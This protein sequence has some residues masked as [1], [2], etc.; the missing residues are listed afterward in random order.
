MKNSWFPRISRIIV[1]II[2]APVIGCGMICSMLGEGLSLLG[3][4]LISWSNRILAAVGAPKV[5]R[6]ATRPRTSR[7]KL[8]RLK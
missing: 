4:T 1:L 3:Q 5:R 7:T 8:T 2:F 6:T